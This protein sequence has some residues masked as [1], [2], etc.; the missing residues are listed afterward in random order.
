MVLSYGILFSYVLIAITKKEKW[1]ADFGTNT[2]YPKP[3]HR[4]AIDEL[5]DRRRYVNINNSLSKKHIMLNSQ[6]LLKKLN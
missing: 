4:A 1:S 6:A 5:M 2:Y 3:K